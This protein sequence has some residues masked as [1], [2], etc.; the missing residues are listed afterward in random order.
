MTRLVVPL[1][2]ALALGAGGAVQAQAVCPTLGTVGA[3]IQGVSD[4]AGLDPALAEA[5]CTDYGRMAE[6]LTDAEIEVERLQAA[7]AEAEASV[8][9]AGSVLM[10]DRSQGC[11]AGWTDVAL[12]EPD[13]FA[14]RMPVAVG[15]ADGRE[16]KAY[17]DVGGA[18]SQ[19]LNEAQLPPHG[20]GLPLAF[21]R[22][23]GDDRPGSSFAPRTTTGQQVA[24]SA[25][26]GREATDRAGA[27][28]PVATMPPYIALFFCRRD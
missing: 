16:F 7:L 20:H 13:L 9:P 21:T 14:S 11:P 26:T 19:R 5:F 23:Q 18:E 22:M 4:S 25:R 3:L 10:V 6:R 27:G 2:L 8:P 28:Q 15:F 17:R 24:I 1:T 12:A